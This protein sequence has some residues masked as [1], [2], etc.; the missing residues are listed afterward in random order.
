MA[1]SQATSSAT[2]AAAIAE[3]IVGSH[4]LKIDGFSATKDLGVGKSIKSST[5]NV[6]GHTWYIECYPNG[7]TPLCASLFMRTKPLPS[8]KKGGQS[9]GR[10]HVHSARL[11]GRPTDR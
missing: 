2:T 1:T 10:M 8:K 5:F 3:T 7:V 6:G 11:C 9:Q 4:M